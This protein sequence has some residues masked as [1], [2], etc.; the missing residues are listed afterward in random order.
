MK[1]FIVTGSSTGLGESIIKQLLKSNHHLHCISRNSNPMLV[2]LAKE[3]NI[4]L[5]EYSFD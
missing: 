2:E 5:T 4:P 3:E 1:H